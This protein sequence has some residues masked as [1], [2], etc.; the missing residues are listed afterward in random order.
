ML[1]KDFSVY[2]DQMRKPATDEWY[3][4]SQLDTYKQN[5]ILTCKVLESQDKRYG[6]TYK[7]DKAY[8]QG[9]ITAMI[10]EEKYPAILWE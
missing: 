6:V 2:I 8:L 7:E 4:T 9:I 10:E 5:G 1:E 3:I